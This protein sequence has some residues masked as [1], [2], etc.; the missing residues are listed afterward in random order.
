MTV[1]LFV[2]LQGKNSILS[3]YTKNTA[4]PCIPSQGKKNVRGGVFADAIKH[5][6]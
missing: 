3:W 2:Y 1:R 5:F 6:G 4:H